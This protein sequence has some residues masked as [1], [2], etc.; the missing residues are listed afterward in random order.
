M[1]ISKS[2]HVTAAVVELLS[3]SQS[4]IPRTKIP[5]ANFS[6]KSSV[7]HAVVRD[8]CGETKSTFFL[9]YIHSRRQCI[10]ICTR[11]TTEIGFIF[12][13]FWA[14]LDVD[15]SAVTIITVVAIVSGVPASTASA[16]CWS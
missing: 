6:D 11:C 2:N 1:A 4:F 10:S 5:K 9:R 14:T 8:L 16:L 15:I 13:V 12:L 3:L 7:V